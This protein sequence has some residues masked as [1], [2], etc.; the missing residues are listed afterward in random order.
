MQRALNAQPANGSVQMTVP[1]K[2]DGVSCLPS[3]RSR[4]ET[5][6]TR[7][8]KHANQERKC[9]VSESV[10]ILLLMLLA[11]MMAETEVEAAEAKA[12]SYPSWTM[13]LLFYIIYSPF[14]NK[15]MFICC[16]SL[17]LQMLSKSPVGLIAQ[18]TTIC[19]I[20]ECSPFYGEISECMFTIVKL[21]FCNG[22]HTNK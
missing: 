5:R 1:I 19:N 13:L 9:D 14:I 17:P 15:L 4:E 20:E 22:Y 18:M 10:R 21:L 11:V 12:K 6:H 8:I 2:S 3:Y 7:V 16:V